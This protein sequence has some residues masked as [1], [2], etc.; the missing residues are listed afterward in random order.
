MLWKF[1]SN[2]LHKLSS[3]QVISPHD[4]RFS[5]LCC[6]ANYPWIPRCHTWRDAISTQSC[7]SA[8]TN[9]AYIASRGYVPRILERGLPHDWNALAHIHTANRLPCHWWILSP[10]VYLLFC[11]TILFCFGSNSQIYSHLTIPVFLTHQNQVWPLC[12]HDTTW[13]PFLTSQR[14]ILCGFGFS[15]ASCHRRLVSIRLG[16]AWRFAQSMFPH[17]IRS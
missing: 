7:T 13:K 4:S 15:V 10:F 12:V 11:L 3:F 9:M 6:R 1:R 17:V 2:R 16:S 14:R 8:M 5:R